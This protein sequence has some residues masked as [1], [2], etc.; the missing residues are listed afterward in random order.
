MKQEPSLPIA[1]RPA[2]GLRAA[3]AAIAV[4]AALFSAAAHG[5]ETATLRQESAG[6]TLRPE[7]PAASETAAETLPLIRVAC[8]D[9][10]GTGD[11][12]VGPK[13]IRRCLGP[14][15]E[16]TFQ[17]VSAEEIRAGALSRFDVFICPGGSGSR[18]SKTLDVEG[19]RAI[20]DFLA[21]GGGYIG[22]CAGA[23]LASSQYTWSLGILNAQVVDREHWARGTGQ[24]SLK[25]SAEGRQFLGV[26]QEAIACYYAQ[27]PLLAPAA[28]TDL[29]AYQALATY[30][31][32]IAENGAPSGIM[33]GTAA[34]AAGQFA[35]GR[36]FC[37]NP[38]PEKTPGLEDF[39]RRAVRW[40]A[41]RDSIDH[42]PLRPE[43]LPA[44]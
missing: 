15:P 41:S 30:D 35:S 3:L 24:V 44:P 22:I 19:R 7:S 16:F 14:S 21:D 34:I 11:S 4:A 5:Q 23:Y 18:Q 40:A 25:L 28:R 27:G 1:L 12:G 9:V 2:V 13:N 33:V 10:Y 39:V 6:D 36:V 17:T 38:H 26:N 31:S 37:F 29:P 8:L 20:L 43:T 32:E 42:P